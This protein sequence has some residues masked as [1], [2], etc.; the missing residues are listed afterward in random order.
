ME[1]RNAWERIYDKAIGELKTNLVYVLVLVLGVALYRSE[2]NQ[3]HI[4]QIENDT[5]RRDRDEWRNLALKAIS[6]N[7]DYV[8]ILFKGG[9]EYKNIVVADSIS[10]LDKRQ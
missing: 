1:N 9:H 2:V 6:R 8:D 10:N 4:Q 7:F 3:N 5:V